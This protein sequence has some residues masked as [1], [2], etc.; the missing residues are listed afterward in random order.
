MPHKLNASHRHKF[1]TEPKYWLWRAIDADG[2]VLDILV[3]PLRNAKAAKRVF[4]RLI[5]QFGPPRVIITDKLR[6]QGAAARLVLRDVDH[7]A[8]KGLNN[9]CEGSHRSTRKRERRW[10][11][12]NHRLRRRDSARLT[13]RSTHSFARADIAFQPIPTAT[14]ETMLLIFGLTT[15]SKCA[16][17]Q[18]SKGHTL[19]SSNNLAMPI[20]R[21]VAQHPYETQSIR[22]TGAH[23]FGLQHRPV[24][25][26]RR[27]QNVQFRSSSG[28]PLR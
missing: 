11:D 2:D 26:A 24:L 28:H 14:Q 1:A 6:S 13:T 9:L 18:R 27:T 7:W 21:L 15:R 10:A 12:S 5:G 23:Q 19:L 22:K 8:H 17:S 4:K 3:Q 16:R 25:L 20:L